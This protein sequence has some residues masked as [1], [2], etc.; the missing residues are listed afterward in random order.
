VEFTDEPLEGVGEDPGEV[1]TYSREATADTPELAGVDVTFRLGNFLAGATIEGTGGAAPAQSDAI[2]I[3]R[4]LEQRMRMALAGKEIPG[5]DRSLPGRMLNFNI[6]PVIE[7]YVSA[8]DGFGAAGSDPLFQ[9]YE[10]GYVRTI[11]LGQ[12]RSPLPV[13]TTSISTFA[14]EDGPLGVISGGDEFQPPFDQMERVDLDPIE[15]ATA[16]AGFHFV[17]PLGEGQ[18]ID[19]YR[20]LS[21]AGNYLVTIDVQAAESE[22]VAKRLATEFTEKQLACIDKGNCELIEQ[23]DTGP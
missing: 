20:I 8:E 12:G 4:A 5:I 7:G 6:P 10:S 1:T 23:V 2:T 17:S 11:P 21:V 13:V 9:D 22:D 19:S 16:V 18:V 15:G 3:A 14:S